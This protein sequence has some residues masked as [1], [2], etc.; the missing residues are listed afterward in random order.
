M[1]PLLRI[2]SAHNCS[3]SVRSSVL[4]MIAHYKCMPEIFIHTTQHYISDKNG[5]TVYYIYYHV[6]SLVLILCAEFHLR[7]C[8]CKNGHCKQFHILWLSHTSKSYTRLNLLLFF[9]YKS[10]IKSQRS[11]SFNTIIMLT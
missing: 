11:S 5:D 6:L 9:V 10:M 4:Y 2:M 8:T 1:T 3:I 7:L